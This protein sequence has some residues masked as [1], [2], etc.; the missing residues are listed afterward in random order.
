MSEAEVE[1]HEREDAFRGEANADAK[2]DF[3]GAS[4]RGRVDDLHPVL[5]PVNLLDLATRPPHA[6]TA[7]SS[8]IFSAV[9]DTKKNETDPYGDGDQSYVDCTFP[10]TPGFAAMQEWCNAPE[11]NVLSSRFSTRASKLALTTKFGLA[12]LQG[13]VAAVDEEIAAARAH[14]ARDGENGR[15]G[16]EDNVVHRLVNERHL[17]LRMSPLMLCIA[18]CRWLGTT[19]EAT[20][21]MDHGAVA[22]SLVAAGADVNARDVMGTSCLYHCTTSQ[23]SARTLRIA[24]DALLATGR[25]EVNTATRAGRTPLQEAVM[26]DAPAPAALLL[27][28]GADSRLCFEVAPADLS[29][30]PPAFRASVQAMRKAPPGA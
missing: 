13:D 21:A 3:I 12:C 27:E 6:V 7:A 18:G 16:K 24:Q 9:S 22:A 1:S 10:G 26:K 2:R 20:A 19:L 17:S 14:A 28:A 30:V 29:A 11:L 15:L 8:Q 4:A 23:C 5:H 25:C